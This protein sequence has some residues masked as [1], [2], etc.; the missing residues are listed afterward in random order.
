[1]APQFFAIGQVTWLQDI[2]LSFC[3]LTDPIQSAGKSNLCFERYVDLVDAS[4]HASLRQMVTRRVADLRAH[5]KFARDHRNRRIAHADLATKLGSNPQPLAQ[6]TKGMIEG[7]FEQI[8][9][10]INEVEVGFD[11]PTTL[12]GFEPVGDG[13]ELLLWLRHAEAYEAAQRARDFG[14][15]QPGPRPEKT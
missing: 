2:Y 11:V 15:F 1:V 13:T 6:V 4:T 5:C 10:L 12:F 14:A 7:A 8:R 9:D 3:R